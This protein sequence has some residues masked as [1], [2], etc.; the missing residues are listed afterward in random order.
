MSNNLVK[1]RN[2]KDVITLTDDMIF[3]KTN[4]FIKDY[5]LP[6]NYNYNN[7]VKSLCLAL[8]DVKNIENASARS[9]MLA[10]Q[11]YVSKGYDISK[12]Q[13]SL[14]V[15]GDQLKVQPQYFGNVAIAK[16]NDEN[17]TNITSSAIYDGDKVVL[18]KIQGR[19]HIEH[20]TSF[21]NM[22]NRVIGAYATVSYK[23]GTDDSE[24]MTI[25]DIEKSWSMARNGTSVHKKF[26]SQ[27]ARKTVLNKLCTRLINYSVDGASADYQSDE[28]ETMEETP[29]NQNIDYENA[30]S[31]DDVEKENKE[32]DVLVYTVNMQAPQEDVVEEVKLQKEETIEVVKEES[33]EDDV[34][35]RFNELNK[36]KEEPVEEVK[37][38]INSNEEYD[39]EHCCECGAKLPAISVEFYRTHKDKPRLCWTCN[40]K[41]K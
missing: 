37:E 25:E 9:I 21:E 22:K 29:V 15:Y 33:Q 4:E 16:K 27:M 19:T 38:E 23:D 14:I 17:I 20:E 1:V 2:G 13:C 35:A 40:S 12:R 10:A 31:L 11:E 7:A 34:I 39:D 32:E 18:S 8:P 28:F 36:E 5:T 24:I 30:I 26:P 3:K 41:R 6:A